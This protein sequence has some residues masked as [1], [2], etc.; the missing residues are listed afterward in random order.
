[1]KNIFVLMMASVLMLAGAP[2]MSAKSDAEAARAE[3]RKTSQEIL[4]ALYKTQPSAKSAI[5]S[6]AGY[7]VFSN[8][9]MKIFFAGGGGGKGVAVN[10]KTGKEIFMKML[11]VQA[12]LGIGIKKFRLV[13]VFENEGAL[14]SFINSGWEGSAQATAA[15]KMGNKGAAY[16]GAMPMSPGVWLYQ[17]TDEGLALEATIKGTKYYKDDELN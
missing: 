11:E 8:F 4:D 17:L 15:A 5:E 12:G 3:V 7:A 2:A 1:M 10:N 9:G 13:F 16:Q 14:N 6:A